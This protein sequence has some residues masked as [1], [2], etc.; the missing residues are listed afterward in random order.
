MGSGF[1]D[2]FYACQWHL[3]NREREREDINVEPVWADGVTGE[4]VNVAVVDN[5]MDHYHEDLSANVNRNFN[6]DYRGNGDVH[7][8]FQHHGTAVAGL[9]SARDNDIGV[10]GVA[11]RATVY[12][13]QLADRPGQL[14]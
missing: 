12:G 9:I 4:G 3:K 2:D 6:H 1:T 8:S 11:P 5:G 13:V 7:G 10:R 14:E